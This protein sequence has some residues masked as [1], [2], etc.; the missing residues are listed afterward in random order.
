MVVGKRQLRSCLAP[1]WCFCLPHAACA[2]LDYGVAKGVMLHPVQV[3]DCTGSTSASTIL[4]VGSL[5][6]CFL[7]PCPSYTSIHVM[8]RLPGPRSSS[9]FTLIAE[10]L[11]SMT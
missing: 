2:G 8:L 10:D 3:L 6:D 1:L 5:L 4:A 7:L 9:C 11:L